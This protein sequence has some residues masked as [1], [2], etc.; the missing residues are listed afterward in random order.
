MKN[1]KNLEIFA[2]EIRLAVLKVLLHCS[3]GHLGGSMSIVELMSVLY[4]KHLQY[5][6][7]EPKWDQRDMVVLSKGHA[8]PA[9]YAALALSGYFQIED[10]YT[11]NQNGTHFPSHPSRLLTPGVDMST[12]SLGQGVSVSAGIALG[13][14]KRKQYNRYVYC[15]CGDGELNEGQ[16]W[17]AFSF[18]AHYKLNH[19]IVVIDENKRQLDG[20][21]KDVMNP[22]DLQKKMEAFGFYTLRVDGKSVDAIDHAISAVKKIQDQAVCIILD[23]VKG[24]GLPYFEQLI[25]NHSVKFNTAEKREKIIEEIKKLEQYLKEK[26]E[27]VHDC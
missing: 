11:L 14:K 19:C 27:Y 23:T 26:N 10:L 7:E 21:T 13:M 4:G 24:Q 9:W 25:D 15:I 2:A 20:Y 8:G 5:R 1:E 12:G 3:Y 18:I 6:P 22:F 17:E 16:C